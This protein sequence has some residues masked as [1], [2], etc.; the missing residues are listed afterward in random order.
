MH[1]L[2]LNYYVHDER[3]VFKNVHCLQFVCIVPKSLNEGGIEVQV[4]CNG[5][6]EVGSHYE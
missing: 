6:L 4:A 3:N 5:D 2:S 1:K